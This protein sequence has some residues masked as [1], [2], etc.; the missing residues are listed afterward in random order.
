[1]V[2]TQP[3]IYVC[4]YRYIYIYIHTLIMII[5]VL[6]TRERSGMLGEKKWGMQKW[7]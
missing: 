6:Q 3:I 4:L 2:Y 1:M 5:I 7:E